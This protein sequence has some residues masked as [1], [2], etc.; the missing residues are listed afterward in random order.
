MTKIREYKYATFNEGNYLSPMGYQVIKLFGDRCVM[1]VS[2]GE[3]SIKKNNVVD[4]V[5]TKLVNDI[6]G[7]N[8]LAIPAGE[9]EMIVD[10]EYFKIIDIVSDDENTQDLP[11]SNRL[12]Y[13]GECFED[14]LIERNISKEI[15]PAIG[16]YSELYRP[17]DS[18]YMFGFDYLVVPAT[19]AMNYMIVGKAEEK[20]D[21][22]LI[23]RDPFTSTKNIPKR[24]KQKLGSDDLE[25][26]NEGVK[27]L[28][29]V[30]GAIV[31]RGDSEFVEI[32]DNQT[33]FLV[34]GKDENTIKIFAK[35]VLVKKNNA[36]I[37][38]DAECVSEPPLNDKGKSYTWAV[39]TPSNLSNIKYFT[40]NIIVGCTV[41][42]MHNGAL[43][44]IK[45]INRLYITKDLFDTTNISSIPSMEIITLKKK[46]GNYSFKSIANILIERLMNSKEDEDL[47]LIS[48]LT[49]KIN[50]VQDSTLMVTE[51]KNKKR[52]HSISEDEDDEDY[53]LTKKL[54]N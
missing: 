17:L 4:E 48:G 11:Y 16:K 3:V 7:S 6:I 39:P 18:S 37:D 1:S 52:T 21:S 8:V 33:V 32:A 50:Q 43:A 5:K 45:A 47:S 34:A 2:N 36:L 9:Y 54:K 41:P 31:K 28:F 38:E 15:N 10:N 44:S 40:K 19:Q 51:C 35:T 24:L 30:P 29:C 49:S 23:S 13:L 46:L 27:S 20:K 53:A 25:V 42:K 14:C 26:I 12:K 22:I